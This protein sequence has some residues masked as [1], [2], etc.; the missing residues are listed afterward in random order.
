TYLLTNVVTEIIRRVGTQ[1]FRCLG[2]LIAAGPTFK[3]LVFSDAV[4]VLLNCL[5]S[6]NPTAKFIESLRQL[7]QEGQTQESLDMLGE[8]AVHNIHALFAFGM[9]LICCGLLEDDL[10]IS[11]LFLKKVGNFEE[12]H[13]IVDQVESKIWEMGLLGYHLFDGTYHFLDIPACMFYHFGP[14]DL[15]EECFAYTYATKIHEMC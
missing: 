4:P 14:V 5:N 1:G 8:P 10:K 6:R 3:A 15:C 13:M 2:P 9:L 11:E 12:A 7:T